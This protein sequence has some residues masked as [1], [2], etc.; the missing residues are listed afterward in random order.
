MQSSDAA[1]LTPRSLPGLVERGISV[2]AYLR[3]GPVG[4]VHLGLGAFHRAHQALVFDQ[5]LARG[6]TRWGVLG[7]AMRQPALANTLAAQAGLY[8]VQLASAQGRR[9]QVGGAI[10]RTALVTHE[11]NV[12]VQ[13]LAAPT[14]RWV[15]LTVTEKAYGPALADL[16]VQGLA[17]RHAAG[18]GGLTLASCDN[19]QDNGRQL[20][21]LC[22]QH[23]AA[24][25][26]GLAHWINSTCAFPN[27][28]VDRIV[29]AGSPAITEQAR[30]ALGLRD[31]AALRTELFWEWVMERRF[32]D[33][34][35]ADVLASAGVQVVDDVRPYEHAKLRLLNGSHSAM[36]CIGAVAGLPVISDCVAEP[37]VHQFVH[38]LMSTEIGPHLQRRDWPGYRDALLARFANPHLQHSVHQIATDSSLKITLRWVPAAVDALQAGQPFTRLAF[39]AAVWMRYWQSVDEAGT[40]YKV[41]DPMA[42]QLQAL[43]RTHA[44]DAVATFDAM[45]RLPTVW[46]EV[47]AHHPAWRTQ[48]VAHLQSIHAHGVLASAANL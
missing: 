35:D 1:L 24:F 27:S 25:N 29:P 37:R 5:L 30:E 43:A 28:M 38:A 26:T 47:L 8:S 19:L 32:V 6:D 21:A 48:V 31:A 15:T 7:V 41:S 11:R 4:V 46:G 23:A 39:C 3:G 2:P 18:H 22:V 44:G 13:T 10:W 14:T 9:W 17:A 40:P 42:D 12:V 33:S 20:Q 34:T 16:L 36:A 45:G